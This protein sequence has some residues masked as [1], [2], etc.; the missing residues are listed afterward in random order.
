MKKFFYAMMALVTLTVFSCKEPEPGPIIDD[1][2]KNAWD[3][4]YSVDVDYYFDLGYG[5]TSLNYADFVNEGKHIWDE[6]E[7]T[8]AEFIDALGS[9]DINSANT[10]QVDHSISFG[11]I[12]GSTGYLNE[13]TSTT[14]GWGH[15]FTAQGDVC[16]WGDDAYFF[17]EG[18]FVSN[19]NLAI[20]LGNFPGRINAGETYTL[21]ECFFN[22]DIT[23]AVQ[24]NIN[25]TDKLPELKLN[26]VGESS[27]SLTIDFD[28][29]YTP[30][31]FPDVD[32]A[33]IATAI[34]CEV[35]AATFYGVDA[36]GKPSSLFKGTDIWYNAEGPASWGAG[37][38]IHFGYDAEGER[39]TTCLYPDETLAGGTYSLTVAV[40]NGSNA[41]FHTLQVTVNAVDYLAFDVLV[42]KEDGESTYT[43]TE[44]NLAALAQ[45]LGVD[46]VAAAEIGDKYPLKGIQADGS[47]YEGGYTANNG[48]WYSSQSNVT[49]WGSEDFCAYIEYR[50][51]YKF[52]CGLWKESG[53]AQTVKLGIGDAV[54]TFNLEV[55]E[56]ANYETTEVAAVAVEGTQA[57][58]DGYSGAA[59]AVDL[60]AIGITAE[61][62]AGS[63]KLFDKE[64]GMEYTANGGFWFDAE[65]AV[66]SWSGASFFVE[67]GGFDDEGVFHLRTGI[68]PDNVKE[69]AE[70][71]GVVRLA[72]IETLQHLTV[73]ITVKVQ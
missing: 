21:K 26:K 20:S 43:L 35:G 57:V 46:S 67:P 44:N 60:S 12:D 24:F 1:D 10:A 5:G 14:N 8:E 59:I 69:A 25:V 38:T 52:G 19:E 3:V 73:T 36:T 29:G 70:F 40:A 61:N 48:Y 47:V 62:Y 56:P 30:Y 68:H 65:G 64:G 32:Y 34:G 54:L 55:D 11:A 22:D 50:G 28:A 17:T 42:S 58:A 37:C 51:D 53:Y 4:L 33:A 15:W 71:V 9:A 6:F 41:W 39:F 66:A 2:D 23:V 7:L 13:T 63:F 18:Y 16:S 45:A 31:A 49:N 72:N 27:S